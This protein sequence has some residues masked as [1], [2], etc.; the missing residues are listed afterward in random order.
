LVDAFLGAIYPGSL[1]LGLG[2]QV[3]LMLPALLLPLWFPRGERR[4][5][6]VIWSQIAAQ[7]FIWV[8]VPYASSGHVFANVRYLIGALGLCFAGVVALAERRGMNDLW[9]RGIAV[10]LL[11]QDLL[12]LHAEM[13]HSV[14]VVLAYTDILAVALAFSPGLRA[15]V[16]RRRRELA[17][18]AVALAVLGAP[19]L[20][21][22]R[23]YDRGRA[24]STEFTAHKTAAPNFAN[25]WHFLDK[26]GGTGTVAVHSLPMDYFIYPAMGT[27]LERRAIYVN[28]NR[29]S[30]RN[31]ADFP[32]CEPRID[33]DP[34][35]W[36]SHLAKQ[37]VRW[38]LVSR[39]PQIG[40]PEE[41]AWAAARPDLFVAR[42]QDN[43]NVIY[44][45][46]P[47]QARRGALTPPLSRLP[48]P[49]PRER[50]TSK[51]IRPDHVIL[52]G[53]SATQRIW[54]KERSARPDPSRSHG[55]HS[56]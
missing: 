13:P 50:G 55:S 33:L 49:L 52:R 11:V 56:G 24:Y 42:Y 2:P 46:L 9:M 31:A 26:Y 16:V 10:A 40:F 14:R 1:E 8:T 32:A 28:V 21:R 54:G 5:A 41:Q 48:P 18:A 25:A 53:A 15:F 12:Q 22:F 23:V 37:D 44:E 35:A 19:F 30:S 36:V 3:V 27:H 34:Q 39:F 4:G 43:S 6:F 20:S 29:S 7:L 47:W 38:V 17:A 51:A 45:F